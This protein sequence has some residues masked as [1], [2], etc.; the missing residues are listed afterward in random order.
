[1][2]QL[3]GKSTFISAKTGEI[4]RIATNNKNTELQGNII[5]K[6]IGATNNWF[7]HCMS[8]IVGSSGSKGRRARLTRTFW[9]YLQKLNFGKVKLSN[10]KEL[11]IDS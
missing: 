8:D 9:S 4:S 10:N 6:I 5:Q 7:G 3:T 1:M 2:D 11:S